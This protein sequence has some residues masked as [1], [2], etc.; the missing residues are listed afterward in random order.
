MTPVGTDQPE[1]TSVAAGAATSGGTPAPGRPGPARLA[2]DAAALIANLQADLAKAAAWARVIA[3]AGIPAFVDSP[4]PGRVA[5]R[6]RGRR[7]RLP[8]RHVRGSPGGARTGN[9][10]VHQQLRRADREVL[11]RQ[12]C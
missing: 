3:P 8:R 11:Q 2:C 10:G 5:G 1:I 4:H 9:R 6:H 7:P 12:T